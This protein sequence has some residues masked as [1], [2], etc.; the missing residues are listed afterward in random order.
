[1]K[2]GLKAYLFMDKTVVTDKRF[3]VGATDEHFQEVEL[4]VSDG[5]IMNLHHQIMRE[6]EDDKDD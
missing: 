6:V 5:D 1:M 4:I 3:I 2:R